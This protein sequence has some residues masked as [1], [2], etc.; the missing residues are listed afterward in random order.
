MS[1][2]HF[3]PFFGLRLQWNGSSLPAVALCEGGSEIGAR[4][5]DRVFHEWERAIAPKQRGPMFDSPDNEGCE[6]RNGVSGSVYGGE[7]GVKALGGR[8][9]IQHSFSSS[10]VKSAHI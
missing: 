10:T 1:I 3:W 9:L 7:G 6:L 4:R 8:D 5:L 2:G